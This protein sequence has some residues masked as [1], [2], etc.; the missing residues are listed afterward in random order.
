M[1]HRLVGFAA[2]IALAACGSGGKKG[3][4]QSAEEVAKEMAELK[5]RPGQWEATNEI[6]SANAPGIPSETLR[7]MVGQKKTVSNCVTPEEAAKPSASFLAGQQNSDCSY[8][9]FAMDDG[10]MTGTMSCSVP[11]VPGK[12]VMKMEG[13]YS[14][15][16]YDMNMDM[17]V[18]IPGGMKMAVKAKTIG[19]RTGECA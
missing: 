1:K 17:T 15:V 5:M 8:Q 19:R 4:E 18:N 2:L 10:R 14:P 3:G 11:G 6:L 7:T 13:K 9:D 16:A 12:T